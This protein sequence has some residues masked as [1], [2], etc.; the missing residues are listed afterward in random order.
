[1]PYSILIVDDN[2]MIRRTLRSCIQQNLDL[3]VCGEAI[4]GREAI[5]RVQQLEPDLVILDLSMP[6]MN[7]LDTARELKRIRPRL[8]VLM[9]T[10]FKTPSL[11]QAAVAAGCDAVVAKSDLQLLFSSVHGLFAT[12]SWSAHGSAG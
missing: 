10:S 3:D 4:D 9:F 11:E 2:P 6:G 7:G 12:Q 8:H 5:E 1:V